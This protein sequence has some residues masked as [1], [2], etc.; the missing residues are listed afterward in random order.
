MRGIT[1]QRRGRIMSR[2]MYKGPEQGQRQRWGR[3]ME[4][5]TWGAGRVAES[6]GGERGTTI[7]EQ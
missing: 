5:G 4:W 7:I 2:N 6:N 3:R 1:G